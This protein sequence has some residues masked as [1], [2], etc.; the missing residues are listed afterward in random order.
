VQEEREVAADAAEALHSDVHAGN[1]AILLRRSV[2]DGVQRAAGRRLLAPERPADRERLA[3]DHPEHGVTLVH[4]VRVEDPR[5][6]R[7]VGADVGRRNV[8]LRPDL[9]DDLARVATRHALEL[10]ARQLLRVDDDAALGAAEGDSHQRALPRHRHGERLDLVERD[11]GV[12]ADAA[13]RRPA[14]DVVRDAVALED[15]RRPIV[16]ADGNRDL[17]RLLALA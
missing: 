4:R 15:A 11:G 7:R 14:R 16:H 3:G 5:H 17:D 12:V 6:H 9:V 2:A 8:F 10:R 13:L 1:R